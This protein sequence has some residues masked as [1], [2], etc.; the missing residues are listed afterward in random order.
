M[1]CGPNDYFVVWVP[2]Y[3]LGNFMQGS[4]CVAS[5]RRGKL[6]QT[7]AIKELEDCE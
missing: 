5:F 4:A 3:K 7:D 1:L 6:C 2:R